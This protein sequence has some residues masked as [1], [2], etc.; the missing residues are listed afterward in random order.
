M[1][2]ERIDAAMGTASAAGTAPAEHSAGAAPAPQPSSSADRASGGMNSNTGDDKPV[3]L[4]SLAA[5]IV[6][7][8]IGTGVFG[9]MSQL[10]QV[11]SPGPALIAW[12]VTDIGFAALVIASNNL[13]RKRPDLKSGM[14][15]YAGALFGRFG[16]FLSGWGYWFSDWIANIA[17]CTMLMSAFGTFFPVFKGGQNWPSILASTVLIWVLA[18]IVNHGMGNATLLNAVVTVC[19]IVPIFVFIAVAALAFKA[20]VFSAQFWQTVGGNFTAGTITGGEIYNQTRNSLLVT[21]WL[22]LGIESAFV[23]SN[24]ARKRSSAVSATVIAFISLAVLYLLVS[25]LPYGVMSRAQLAGLGQPAMGEVMRQLVGPWGEAFINVGLIVSCLGA[26]LSWTILPVEATAMMAHDGVMPAYW[27]KLNRHGAPTVSLM[28]TAAAQTVF[29]LTFLVTP[30]AYN[31]CS[32]LDV[33]ASLLCYLFIC[34]YQIRYSV[35][36][37]QWWQL[38]VGLVAAAFQFAALV[39]SGWKYLLLVTILY[40][41][42]FA[43]YIRASA[44]NGRR[45]GRGEWIA[46]GV[47][48]AVAV[49]AIALTIVGV[50]TV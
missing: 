18:L 1:A 29:L 46:M 4:F 31:F 41:A 13:A 14:F 24:R 48:A 25:L 28:I 6:S 26:L 33:A 7:A 44:Q 35:Q 39:L 42:G 17:F 10:A 3:G 30:N 21:V 9:V 32:A 12:L 36:Q 23:M 22:L 8:A 50:I 43:L 15:S 40:T 37:R 5:L 49:L 38:A 2:T 45:I 27:G 47:I 19:K 16:E 11:A 20:N 34:M